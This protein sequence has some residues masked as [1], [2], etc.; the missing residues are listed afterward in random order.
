MQERCISLLI[1]SSLYEEG[2]DSNQIRYLNSGPCGSNKNLW[3]FY[4][5]RPVFKIP[6]FILLLAKARR[7]KSKKQY[8]QN[9]FV[10]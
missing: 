2:K 4:L 10:T 5:V 1:F 8:I 9:Q 6:K 3:F 7:E